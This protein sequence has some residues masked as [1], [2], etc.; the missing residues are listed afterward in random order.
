MISQPQSA[1]VTIF[2][3]DA[4]LAVP[5]GISLAAAVLGHGAT[6]E[7][8]FCRAATEADPVGEG[9]KPYCFMGVCFDCLVEV[10][11]VP[12]VQAC[13]TTVAEGMRVRLPE[14]GVSHG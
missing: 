4:P 3:D 7:K 11:G 1:T 2:V 9:R 12:N 10:N 14:S 6:K 8:C 5:E 13:L